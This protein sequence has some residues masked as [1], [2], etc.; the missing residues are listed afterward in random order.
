MRLVE[1]A[2]TIQPIG[3]SYTNRQS[4]PEHVGADSKERNREVQ[5]DP[6]EGRC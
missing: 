5:L 2:V 6:L 4:E 1:Q 3:R